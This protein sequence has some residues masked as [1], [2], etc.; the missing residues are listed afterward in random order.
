MIVEFG[1]RPRAVELT[2]AAPD[3]VAAAVGNAIGKDAGSS[4]LI[5]RSV[6]RSP[7][8]AISLKATEPEIYVVSI[9]IYAVEEQSGAP[10][11]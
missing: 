3:N 4:T 11:A 7:S 9:D 5:S 1:E 8:R 10:R 6:R 2:P